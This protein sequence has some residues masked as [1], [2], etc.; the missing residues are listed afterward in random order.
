MSNFVITGSVGRIP[1]NPFG[2]PVSYIYVN[3]KTY[4]FTESALTRPVLALIEKGDHVTLTFSD[5]LGKHEPL[6]LL[7]V[8]NLI[9]E[10]S[11]GHDV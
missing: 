5:E 9:L 2:G 1:L 7:H 6:M 10:Q 4:E 3:G 8:R 11:A